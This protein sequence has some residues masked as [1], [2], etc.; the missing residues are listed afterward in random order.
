[1]YLWDVVSLVVGIFRIEI[2][3]VHVQLISGVSPVVFST[4]ICQ[5]VTFAGMSQ[6]VICRKPVQQTE[7]GGRM[8]ISLYWEVRKT[9]I[10]QITGPCQQWLASVQHACDASHLKA[11][12]VETREID[13]STWANKSTQWWLQPWLHN[14]SC[15][16]GIV[17]SGAAKK[18]KMLIWHTSLHVPRNRHL[19]MAV[20]V[21]FSH[22]D[23][24]EIGF[25]RNG[26]C[27]VVLREYVITV[28][29][30]LFVLSKN[31]YDS[32]T[33]LFAFENT[34][35]VWTV[36]GIA[37]QYNSGHLKI[38]GEGSVLPCHLSLSVNFDSSR[39]SVLFRAPFITL[40]MQFLLRKHACARNE[41]G[42]R[43]LCVRNAT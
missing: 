2:V 32:A 28:N 7:D 14:A 21:A 26:N 9:N 34:H 35:E 13:L 24:F 3:R 20:M 10:G 16:S 23:C 43:L 19:R 30:N 5:K 1:M 22:G 8:F 6:Y 38:V 18:R 17:Y 37:T 36:I 25:V 11:I 27:L 31:N 12:A 33:I 41:N 29:V 42:S 4:A 40:Y 39:Q 15:R